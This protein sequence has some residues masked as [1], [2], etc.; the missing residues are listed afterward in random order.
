MSNHDFV[1]AYT[2]DYAEWLDERGYPRPA[3]NEGNRLPTPAEVL[4]VL[5]AV[6]DSEVEVSDPYAFLCPPGSGAS[7]GYWLRL[8]AP[9][10]SSLTDESWDEP[11]YFLIKADYDKELTVVIAL[12]AG[13]GQL[14]IY[15]DTGAVPVIVNGSDDP[16]AVAELLAQADDE[17]DEWQA[18]HQLRYG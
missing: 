17:P 15:P 2:Q 12:A 3:V 16:A 11:G 5:R 8:E 7:G 10:E 13:C 6:P 1:M 14:L 4:A 9:A 18:F